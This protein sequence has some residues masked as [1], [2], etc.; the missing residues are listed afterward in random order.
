MWPFS[1]PSAQTAPEQAPNRPAD[2]GLATD[3][4][5]SSIPRYRG[6]TP[7]SS[8]TLVPTSPTDARPNAEASTSSCPVAKQENG[9]WVYPSPSQFYTALSRKQREPE[10][11]RDMYTVVPIHNAVNE[12][13]WAMI[14]QWEKYGSDVERKWEYGAQQGKAVPMLSSFVGRAEDRSPRAWLKTL[15]G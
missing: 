12:R 10:N 5:V 4:E 7:T 9:N 15:V 14:L 11:P 8:T 2:R 6:P 3:R 13:V 1:S